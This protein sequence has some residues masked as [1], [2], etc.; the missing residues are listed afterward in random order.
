MRVIPQWMPT[1]TMV[2]V[3]SLVSDATHYRAIQR[4]NGQSSVGSMEMQQSCGQSSVGSMEMQQ[5]CGQKYGDA[6]IVWP[7]I[8]HFIGY[9]SFKRHPDGGAVAQ[10]VVGRAWGLITPGF[11]STP[12][13]S[14]ELQCR[15]GPGA[16]AGSLGVISDAGIGDCR[17]VT[18]TS[19]PR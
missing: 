16:G 7:Q 13:N 12:R 18:H 6:T 10:S 8:G 11:D 2:M 14:T 3:H 1:G 4:S 19:L 9:G 17:R 5:L 15:A